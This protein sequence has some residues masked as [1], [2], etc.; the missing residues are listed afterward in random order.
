LLLVSPTLWSAVTV[1]VVTSGGFA[2]FNVTA[3]SL[4]HRAVPEGLV[5]RVTAAA[6]VVTFGAAGLGTLLGGWLAGV[7]GLGTPFLLSGVL[8]G[9]AVVWWW[10]ASRPGSRP[11]AAAA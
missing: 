7:A 2:L 4:R 11:S 1:T 9:V 5:G 6:R 3:L 8:A 10:T